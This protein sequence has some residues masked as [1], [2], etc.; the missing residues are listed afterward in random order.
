MPANLTPQ[1]LAADEPSITLMEC[2][3][4]IEASTHCGGKPE[5]FIY[6]K[7]QELLCLARKV[8]GL[9]VSQY[10][11]VLFADICGRCGNCCHDRKV[12][13]TSEESAAMA[14]YIGYSPDRFSSECVESACTWQEGDSFLKQRDGACM[15]LEKGV[16]S[17][18]HCSI[19]PVRP[20]ACRELRPDLPCCRKEP[21]ELIAHLSS[22]SFAGGQLTVT[23]RSSGRFELRIDS[24]QLTEELDA[25][26]ALLSDLRAE[27]PDTDIG[28]LWLTLLSLR[29]VEDL[30]FRDGVSADLVSRLSGLIDDIAGCDEAGSA[31][32]KPLELIHARAE[33]L[34]AMIEGDIDAISKPSELEEKRIVRSR[35]L[36]DVALVI[37]SQS[38]SESD[39][40]VP[41]SCHPELLAAV[42]E[43]VLFIAGIPDPVVME[44]M[45]HLDSQ[46]FLCGEC[47]RIFSVEI[48]PYDIKCLAE[49]LGLSEDDMW[50]H[51]LYP[52]RF[53]WNGGNGILKKKSD[54]KTEHH[55]SPS[56][57]VFLDTYKNERHLCS[58]YE[59]RPE[60]C[61]GFS[62]DSLKCR[63]KSALSRSDRL[64]ENLRYMDM[65]GDSLFLTTARIQAKK[66]GPLRVYAKRDDRL[67]ALC[68]KIQE[69]LLLAIE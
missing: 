52:G 12:R 43:L 9:V 66:S 32:G 64:A 18:R 1:Y 26:R 49:H 10:G 29:D 21:A 2:K 46:C 3:C 63:E 33:R 20:A 22:I 7:S 36:P 35:L 55:G 69:A 27:P 11:A 30:Y 13:V 68:R 67:L 56:D 24:A 19:Y 8:A 60:V 58:V 47:C 37:I 61:R 54:L 48:T 28:R 17:F 44:A 5:S 38:G 31:C 51:Y 14:S 53:S 50:K 34:V 23:T 40:I 16:T 42:R 62:S 59:A 45:W 4:V 15:F 65:D 25:I 6:V 57:C 41:Y 39:H